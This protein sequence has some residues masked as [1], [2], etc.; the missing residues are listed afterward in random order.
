MSTDR[1]SR[2]A[3]FDSVRAGYES[4][5]RSA[6]NPG[7]TRRLLAEHL[8]RVG[9]I[10][11]S[12]DIWHAEVQ[13]GEDGT[14]WMNDAIVDAMATGDLAVAGE[15]AGIFAASRWASRWRPPRD[16]A[17]RE[18]PLPTRTP[19][20]Y[21]SVPKLDHDMAQ[22]GLLRQR[23]VLG[24]E[25]DAIIADYAKIADRL[26]P[27]GTNSRS[28]MEADDERRIG[29][30]YSRIVHVS[31]AGRLDHALSKS[32]DRAAVQRQYLQESP[33]LVVIDDFL[34][35]Q[36]LQAL[37]RF[38]EES[39]VWSGNR[40][41]D[42]RLGAFFFAGFNCPLLLQIADE[43]RVQLPEVIGRRHPLR[44][45]W[46]FKNS[47][48]LPA[49]STVH[50]DFAAVNANF[51][52]TPESANL[53]PD[54][55]GL[56]VYDVAAPLSWD[57]GTYNESL[58]Y[59]RRYLHERQAR[60]VT[61][62]YRQNRAIIF[63]SDLFHATAQIRFRPEYE[64]RRVNITMLYGDREQDEHHPSPLRQPEPE[65]AAPYAWRSRAFRRG[66]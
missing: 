41:A 13:S 8:V 21:L 39:T 30:V 31:E 16:S 29:H 58:E 4:A 5:L 54:S 56:V 24:A 42:G 25:F 22:F 2:D 1:E 49:D 52:I 9:R 46:G 64:N 61:I 6:M 17:G 10:A 26:R 45:L 55:G 63:N 7:R 66:R 51:W 48:N 43:L 15:L 23:G 35:P 60:A 14:R 57:F 19:N 18:L 27:L 44:Q 28:P 36:A 3:G 53:D 40:Y 12:R 50:A 34:S 11:D 32:W 59:I 37:R 65:A 20:T 33:G 38:C 47:P 62:P